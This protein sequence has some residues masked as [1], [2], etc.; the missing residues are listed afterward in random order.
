MYEGHGMSPLSASIAA[1]EVMREP[2]TALVVH[3]REELGVDPGELGSPWQ[4][5]ALSLVC[6]LVGALV[7]VV[8]WITGGGT[9]AKVA[10]IAIGVGGAAIVGALIGRFA[11]TGIVRSALRQILILVLACGATYLVGRALGVSV[12]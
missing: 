8:P 7:P 6:F 12:A 10:S 4:A 1:E 2:E 11:E 5:A 3:A 9:A